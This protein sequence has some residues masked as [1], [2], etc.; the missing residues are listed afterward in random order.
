MKIKLR[1]KTFRETQKR[2]TLCK[3]RGT[4]VGCRAGTEKAE[5]RTSLVRESG[6]MRIKGEV[7]VGAERLEHLLAFAA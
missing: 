1:Q 3:C 2:K 4:N 5:F 6:Q 7:R